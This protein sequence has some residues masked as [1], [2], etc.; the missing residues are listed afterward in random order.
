VCVRERERVFLC[1]HVCVEVCACGEGE[2]GGGDRV[3]GT[4]EGDVNVC[5]CVEAVCVCMWRMCVA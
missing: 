1:V 4:C 5:I 2:W 3:R